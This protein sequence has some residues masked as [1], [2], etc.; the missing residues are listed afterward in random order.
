MYFGL[1]PDRSMFLLVIL[2]V[3]TRLETAHCQFNTPP[4]THTETACV[5]RA[6]QYRHIKEPEL[7]VPASMR[8]LLE[9]AEE[10]ERRAN[11]KA[12]M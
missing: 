7:T 1:T 2:L 6:R 9:L 12:N 4:H 5:V 11:E 10:T 8:V 3:S